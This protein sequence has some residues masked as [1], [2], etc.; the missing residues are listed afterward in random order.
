LTL[1]LPPPPNFRVATVFFYLSDVES[2]GE[3]IFFREGGRE[4]PRDLSDCSDENGL[5]VPPRAGKV[6]IFYSLNFGGDLDRFSLHG[7]CPV[8]TGVKWSGNKWLWNTPGS[9]GEYR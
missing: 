1:L 4:Q 6:I 8:G 3:T 2:G 5:K 9:L 7:G